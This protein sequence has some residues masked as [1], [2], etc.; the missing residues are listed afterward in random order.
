MLKVHSVPAAEKTDGLRAAALGQALIFDRYSCDRRARRFAVGCK[1]T[2]TV[3]RCSSIV[4]A[5]HTVSGAA[6][7]HGRSA[8]VAHTDIGQRVFLRA[9][10]IGK[11][12]ISV[13]GRQIRVDK[14]IFFFR[15]KVRG[16]IFIAVVIKK[17]LRDIFPA[18]HN[19]AARRSCFLARKENIE[20]TSPVLVNLY[21]IDVDCRCCV[22]QRHRTVAVGRV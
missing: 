12:G 13:A 2:H 9:L 17:D 15:Q 4:K 10:L 3:R 11:E 18:F 14:R 5:R 16:V 20:R 8:A 7:K 19:G 6:V 21:V 22:D 1:Q